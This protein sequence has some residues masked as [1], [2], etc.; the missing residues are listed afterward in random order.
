M[1]KLVFSIALN[2]YEQGYRRCLE[3]QGYYARCIGAEHAVIT[4]P[5]VRDPALSAWLKISLLSR[6][7]KTGYDWVAY[8]DADCRVASGAPD[9]AAHFAEREE[10]VLMV[11]GRSGRLNSGVIFAA[12][13]PASRTF[14]ERVLRSA[15]EDVPI[16]HRRN[17]KYE[18]GNVIHVA[19]RYGGVGTAGVEWN[20]SF[21]PA[22]DDYIRHYTGDMRSEYRR[23]PTDAAR[24]ALARFVSP[25][26]TAAPE[27][28]TGTFVTELSA[29]TEEIVQR[30]SGGK[31]TG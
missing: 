4:K 8:V 14:F 24:F 22:L 3:T 5:R 29:L 18:N 10:S 13:T 19:E 16:E 28:R 21:E 17:L 30:H 1:K 12:N 9:F 11:T 27:R 26:P 2:G 25:R 7:L 15:T 23:P 31:W 6:A 20:N